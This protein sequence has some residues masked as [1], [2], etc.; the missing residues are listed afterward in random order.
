MNHVPEKGLLSFI[1][2]KLEHAIHPHDIKQMLLRAGFPESHIDDAFAHIRQFNT[3]I[4]QHLSA[5]NDFL[6]PLS[7]HKKDEHGVHVGAQQHHPLNMF[8][9]DAE[10]AHAGNGIHDVHSTMQHKGLFAGRLRRKDFV[11]GF[12]FF[13][14][15]GYITLAFS[16]L[17][18]SKISPDM[19]QYILDTIS[20]DTQNYFLMLIP[21]LLAPITIISISLIT[22]RLHNLGLP[23]GIAF[24]YLVIFLPAF[25]QVV[26]YGFAILEIA[27]LILFIVLVTVKGNPAPNQYGSLPGSRGS[28]FRRIFNV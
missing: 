27:L 22:R 21:V 17:L 24:L 18:L 9:K 7:K 26:E 3:E 8:G 1:K 2:T 11:L 16:G 28:F 13:F 10:S 4:H 19:W 15:V 23:G 6:P 25:S 14:G 20:S 12:L 5:V